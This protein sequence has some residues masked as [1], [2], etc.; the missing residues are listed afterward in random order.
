MAMKNHDTKLI[1]QNQFVQASLKNFILPIGD[2]F[3]N[4]LGSV[5]VTPLGGVFLTPPGGGFVT[6][7]GGVLSHH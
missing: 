6:P 4:L 3:V 7:S 1:R 2:D 5:F